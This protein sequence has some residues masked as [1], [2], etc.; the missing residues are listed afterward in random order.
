MKGRFQ[1][2]IFG[3]DICQEVCPWNRFSRPT[4]EPGFRPLGEILNFSIQDW[5]SLTEEDF[6]RIFSHSPLKRAK[7]A[8]LQRNIRFVTNRAMEEGHKAAGNRTEPE[9]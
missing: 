2:W 7:F 8:G 4:P 6:K 1:N 3:C 9:E 5:Q